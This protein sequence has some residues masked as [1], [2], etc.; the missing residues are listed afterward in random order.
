MTVS[1]MLFVASLISACAGTFELPDVSP[2]I[3]LPASG[4]GFQRSTLTGKEIR[5]PAPEWREKT[6]RGIILFSDDWAKLKYTLLKNCITNEC[7]QSVGALDG[8][9]YAIDGALK[10]IPMK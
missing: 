1:S 5:T 7:K 3:T 9:F 4:D 8:L 2:G 10:Q 6:K